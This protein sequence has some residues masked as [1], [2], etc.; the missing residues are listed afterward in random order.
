MAKIWEDEAKMTADETKAC[1]GK[2]QFFL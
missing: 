1:N 2:S